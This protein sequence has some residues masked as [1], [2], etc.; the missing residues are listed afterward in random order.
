MPKIK[1]IIYFNVDMRGASQPDWRI[2]GAGSSGLNGYR[3]VVS[4]TKF[5]GTIK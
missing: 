5:K 1:G 2:T 3:A 4:Q